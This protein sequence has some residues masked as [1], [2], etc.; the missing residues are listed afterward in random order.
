[1]LE[2]GGSENQVITAMP[3][4]ATEDQGAQHE[5][6]VAERFGPVMARTVRGCTDADR[7]PTAVLLGW[8]R[9]RTANPDLGPSKLGDSEHLSGAESYCH[10]VSY[11]M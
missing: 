7:L 2:Y 10:E 9:Y 6:V 4:D 1:M 8:R 5:P 11:K 3:R